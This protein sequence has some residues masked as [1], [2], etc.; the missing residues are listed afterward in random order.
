[1]SFDVLINY[2]RKVMAKLGT[3]FLVEKRSVLPSITISDK[4]TIS[5][6]PS[7]FFL[8][9]FYFSLFITNTFSGKILEK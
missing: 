7:N 4:T 9:L 8:S 6:R 3:T 1:M 5:D 2:G